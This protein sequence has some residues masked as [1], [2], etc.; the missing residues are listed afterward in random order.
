MCGLLTIVC[1]PG[2]FTERQVSSALDKIGHRGPDGRLLNRY[3][4]GIFD[5]WMGHVRL[6]ILDLSETGAQPMELSSSVGVFNGEIYNHR[7]LRK[8]ISCEFRGSSDTETLLAGILNEGESF[9][10]KCNGMFAFSIYDKAKRTILLARD[11]VGKKPL[12]VFSDSGTLIASSELKPIIELLGNLEIDEESLRCF[13]Q[14]GFV[15]GTAS[16]FK[17]VA[18][19]PAGTFANISLRSPQLQKVSPIQYWDPFESYARRSSLT[20][21]DAID[22]FLELLDDATRLRTISDVPIGLFLSGGVDSSLVA[23]SLRHLNHNVTAYTAKFA[24]SQY[25]ESDVAMSLGSYLGIDVKPMLISSADFPRQMSILSKH[26]D[27]PFAD[28]SQIPTMALSESVAKQVKV[29]LTGDGGDEPFLGYPR[30]SYPGSMSRILGYLDLVPGGRKLAHRAFSSVGI[31]SALALLLKSFKMSSTHLDSKKKRLR[32]ILEVSDFWD[33]Y[34]QV[35][36]IGTVSGGTERVK[37]NERL[38]SIYPKYSWQNLSDRS[39]LEYLSAVDLVGYLRDDVLVKADRASMAYGLELRSPLLD[40]RI[41][42][43]AHSLPCE[44]KAQGRVC[45]RILRDALLRRAPKF[46]TKLPKK[47]FSTPIPKSEG[48]GSGDQITD[49]LTTVEQDWRQ[50]YRFN[51]SH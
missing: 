16:I 38:K 50:C 9:I 19:F 40:Y 25:D 5:V 47:G 26:F 35:M 20:Y 11:R 15:M 4:D 27:E 39:Q 46:I 45:K 13:R 48:Q 34:T 44:F 33:V 30:Y 49:W 31:D 29:V 23:T 51:G 12:Y 37:L 17:N 18:K 7:E 14:F 41:I 2:R 24:M 43:F 21:S 3:N 32:G 28:S 8:D 10:K 1:S 6:A 36:S 42:E 22:A